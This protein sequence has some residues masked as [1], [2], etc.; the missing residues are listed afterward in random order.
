MYDL[1]IIASQTP[2]VVS[3]PNFEEVK[4]NLQEYVD[5]KF[6]LVDYTAEGLSAAQSDRDELKKM[7]DAVTK[8]EKELKEAYSAPYV[9]IEKMLEELV[10]I[11][12]AP[13]KT[14]K[15]YA[16]KAEKEQKE[17]DIR[18]YAAR[19]ASAYGEVGRKI[20]ESPAFFKKDWLLKKVFGQKI[21]GRDRFH[22][23]AGGQ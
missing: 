6:S 16:E 1:S 21:S 23:P 20:A 15:D 12:D 10:A 7:R 8:T 17:Q 13:Y 4:A 14:A 2:G 19:Q 18:A 5:S 3:F 11:I 9:P 22:A